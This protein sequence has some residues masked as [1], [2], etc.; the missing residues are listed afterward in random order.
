MTH[1]AAMALSADQL[2]APST[3]QVHNELAEELETFATMMGGTCLDKFWT[4]ERRGYILNL[5]TRKAKQVLFLIKSQFE[6]FFEGFSGDAGTRRSLAGVPSSSAAGANCSS[7][8]AS[9]DA[10]LQAL[11][12]RAWASIAHTLRAEMGL[13]VKWRELPYDCGEGPE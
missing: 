9:L 13:D 5:P 4:Y 12:R 1:Q 10:A 7:A 3:T 11:A 6:G 8:L 2:G